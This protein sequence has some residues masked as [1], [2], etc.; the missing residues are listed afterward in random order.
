MKRS[1]L[2]RVSAL[3]FCVLF[4]TNSFFFVVEAEGNEDA[5][6]QVSNTPLVDDIIFNG[7]SSNNM[8]IQ[9]EN[10]SSDISPMY[11]TPETLYLSTLTVEADTYTDS[12]YSYRNYS[13]ST[14]LKISS[15]WQTF[16][17]FNLA[18][19]PESAVLTNAFVEVSYYYNVTSG[20]LDIGIYKVNNAWDES[21]LNNII[22]D[23]FAMSSTAIDTERATASSSV[24]SSNP[25]T[26]LF[27]ITSIAKE[28][29]YEQNRSIKGDGN[30]IICPS[31]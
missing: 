22:A 24:T 6:T 23:S 8:I 18:S 10:L 1:W 12:Y 7:E 28:W 11:I 3:F 5:V 30:V 2:I 27:D 17:K 20:Y 25:E 16:L 19:I 15:Q 29:V 9:N 4:T 21:T 31:Y 14:D 13:T 26:L